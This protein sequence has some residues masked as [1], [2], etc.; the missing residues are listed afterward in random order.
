[1]LNDNFCLKMKMTKEDGD[2]K[3][4]AQNCGGR[5]FISR[6]LLATLDGKY[7]FTNGSSKV[8]VFNTETGQPVGELATGPNVGLANDEGMI[9]SCI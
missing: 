4:C 9:F 5:D 8:T 3:L 2:E 6:P 1:M 7:I